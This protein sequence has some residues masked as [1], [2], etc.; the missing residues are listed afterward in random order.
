MSL[1]CFSLRCSGERS[2]SD[3][4]ELHSSV[5]SGQRMYWKYTDEMRIGQE[6][7]DQT[8]GEKNTAAT[9]TE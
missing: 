9:S 3:V 2:G 6:A 7:L 5:L 4:F 1:L 8:D